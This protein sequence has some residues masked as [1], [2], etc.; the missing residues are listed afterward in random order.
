MGYSAENENAE[1]ILIVDD[2]EV[3]LSLLEDLL[4][5]SG[6]RIWKA[7]SGG[8]ALEVLRKA[9]VDLV[10]LDRVMPDMDGMAVTRMIK[11]SNSNEDFL[12][13]V[14]LTALSSEDDRVAGL[15]YADDYITKPFS[16]DE[17]LARLRSFLRIRRL[18]RELVKSQKRYKFLY[19]HFPHLFVTLDSDS[20]ITEC[21]HYFCSCTGVS[22][23]QAVGT[24]IMEY[25]SDADKRPFLKHLS[26]LSHQKGRIESFRL[27]LS[28]AQNSIADVEVKAIS[29]GEDHEGA[30]VILS[31]EDVTEKLRMEQER[32]IARNQLYRS[33]RLAS[34]GV[35]ASGVAHEVN[36]P[37]T[38]ILGFSGA[39]IDRL[40]H[41]EE[42]DV[43]ELSQYLQIISDEA[44]RCRNI[45]ENL[46]RFARGGG[47]CEIKVI[48]LA[49]C[50][51][52]ALK[53]VHSRAVRS[54]FTFETDV[55]DSLMVKADPNKLEQALINIFTNCFDFCLGGCEVKISA[56]EPRGERNIELKV[57]DAGPGMT[58]EVLSKA[59]DPFFT[60]KEVGRGTGM[61]LALCYSIM[62]ECNG[63]MDIFSDQE[64][65]GTSV[66][67][68]IPKAG[69]VLG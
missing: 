58:S 55:D 68:E 39:L 1:N 17:L 32:R 67:L 7:A 2:S 61:G 4:S 19:E 41:D 34:I 69:G 47:E 13:V 45:V 29:L 64:N 38:A 20:Q 44:L 43:G 49:D 51:R 3:A 11:N 48:C 5:K 57:T 15:S 21:N 56:V 28:A 23:S 31:M 25:V 46:S 9:P 36:N 60:T 14:M 66:L 27:Q 8:E 26:S 35:L 50:V 12:P 54:G 42:I 37:L 63:K 6:Y 65:G 62:E 18:H 52:N 16:N 33:A 10:L 40:Q 30:S 24:A 22:R 59:F 53:L